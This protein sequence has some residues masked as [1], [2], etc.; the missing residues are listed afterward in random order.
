MDLLV[1]GG[2]GEGLLSAT[3][4]GMN[5]LYEN[6]YK[7]GTVEAVHGGSSCFEG[8]SPATRHSY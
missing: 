8:Y 2:G 6:W 1:C 4:R 3:K 7:N 5:T